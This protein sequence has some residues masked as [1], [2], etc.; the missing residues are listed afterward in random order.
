VKL[1]LTDTMLTA[2]GAQVGGGALA[3]SYDAHV[4]AR[5]MV[6]AANTARDW[7]GAVLLLKNATLVLDDAV[8]QGN[9]A[10]SGGGV[11]AA[12]EA[13]MNLSSSVLAHNTA[14]YG[15]AVCISGWSKMLLEHIQVLESSATQGGVFY[16]EESA[17][18][19]IDDSMFVR[20]LVHPSKTAMDV[21]GGFLMATGNT[22]TVITKTTI[23]GH[24]SQPGVMGGAIYIDKNASLSLSSCTLSHFHAPL[25]GGGIVMHQNSSV[26]A[27]N[28]TMTNISL[29][30][31]GGALYM[32]ATCSGCSVAWVGSRFV[33]TSANSGGAMWI[34][35]GVV[36]LKDVTI[37]NSQAD[38][39]GGALLVA[40]GAH[41][42][43]TH[44]SVQGCRSIS[45][46]G[47][48][49]MA[50]DTS[51]VN[52]AKCRFLNCTAK[53][54][55]AAAAAVGAASL[56]LQSCLFEQNFAEGY[57]GGVSVGGV[58]H[59]VA[60]DCRLL[61][62]RC[63]S[64]GGGLDC[65]G[66][67]SVKLRS[68]LI[69]KNEAEL[70]GGGINVVDQAIVTMLQTKVVGNTAR[71]RGGGVAL[72]SPNFV[73]EQLKAAVHE[74][75]AGMAGRDV[76]A[77]P[78][79]VITNSS[80]VERFVSRL[81]SDDGL[82]NATIRVIGAQGLPSEGVR[83]V[84]MLN[85]VALATTTSGAHGLTRLFVK[86]RQPP[87]MSSLHANRQPVVH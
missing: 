71:Y 46:N 75:R 43:M 18:A 64:W 26:Y 49:M 37:L 34:G 29:A 9:I 4:H 51:Q 13:C 27:Y 32:G 10:K 50:V 31:V 44:C 5:N 24:V 48:G 69:S 63:S 36:A 38:N 8:V 28:T 77:V 58:V 57:G 56:H 22:A 79:L 74:N 80:S 73:V 21:L 35:N 16:L 81:N 83:I 6:F 17:Q 15:G 82:V 85:G 72:E 78:T 67:A 40:N 41:V 23:E 54:N 87:G 47:G 20:N 7:G 62:N 61:A 70:S 3:L 52:M 65:R 12:G 45:G 14:E 55:G 60:N 19:G 53:F 59:L 66:N 2:N 30:G 39:N 11:Y 76:Y 25:A 1:N 42:A 84:A 68:C 33:N 86:L